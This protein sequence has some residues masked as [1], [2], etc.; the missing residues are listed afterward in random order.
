M[1]VSDHPSLPVSLRGKPSATHA[2]RQCQSLNNNAR[3]AAPTRPTAKKTGMT[4]AVGIGN[5]WTFPE[6]RSDSG[7]A[8][9]LAGVGIHERLL[10]QVNAAG[11]PYAAPV[12]AESLVSVRLMLKLIADQ[13]QKTT[14]DE[15]RLTFVTRLAQE[16]EVACGWECHHIST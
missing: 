11:R 10:G 2:R 15:V 1:V 16:A 9:H 6:G 8:S 14:I 13:V 3:C 5:S 4:S 7:K 12:K